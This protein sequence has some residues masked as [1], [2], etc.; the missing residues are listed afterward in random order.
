M[1]REKEGDE[2]KAKRTCQTKVAQHHLDT[3]RVVLGVPP[4]RYVS[5][6]IRLNRVVVMLTALLQHSEQPSIERQWQSSQCSTAT[7][8]RARTTSSKST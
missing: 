1:L 8:P 3:V 7:S 4:G 2:A 6:A 5:S